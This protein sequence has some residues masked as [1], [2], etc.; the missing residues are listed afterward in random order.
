[1]SGGH[2]VNEQQA[3]LPTTVVISHMAKENELSPRGLSSGKKILCKAVWCKRNSPLH[4]I[5]TSLTQ[6]SY[7]LSSTEMSGDVPPGK[8][9]CCHLSTLYKQALDRDE[10]GHC[11][12]KRMLNVLFFFTNNFS[13][14]AVQS[15]YPFLGNGNHAYLFMYCVH[16]L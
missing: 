8:R 10:T 9:H 14:S 1:M 4:N 16:I 3:F 11:R 7:K 5:V 12:R 13:Y 15:V 6:L 2:A